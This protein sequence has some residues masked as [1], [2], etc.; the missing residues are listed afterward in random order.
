MGSRDD[1]LG[2]RDDE[3]GSRDDELGPHTRMT[4]LRLRDDGRGALGC[5]ATPALR[6][7]GNDIAV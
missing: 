1:E 5:D 3:L 4:G 6:N 2:S 7:E